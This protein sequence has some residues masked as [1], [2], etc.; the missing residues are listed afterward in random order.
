MIRIIRLTDAWF[1]RTAGVSVL[2]IATGEPVQPLQFDAHCMSGIVTFEYLADIK[3]RRVYV[4]SGWRP[5]P[6]PGDRC[7][8]AVVQLDGPVCRG[9]HD[10]R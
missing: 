9:P 10:A 6:T 2:R 7:V 8:N 3:G 1:D 4:A 5:E